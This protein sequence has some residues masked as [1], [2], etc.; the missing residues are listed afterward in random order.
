MPNHQDGPATRV[1]TRGLKYFPRKGLLRGAVGL[2]KQAAGL[3]R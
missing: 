2:K 1:L 3:V